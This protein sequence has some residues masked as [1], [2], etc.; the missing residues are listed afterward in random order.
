M[1]R[2]RPTFINIAVFVFLVAANYLLVTNP[3][4]LMTKLGVPKNSLPYIK[5]SLLVLPPLLYYFLIVYRSSVRPRT[6]LTVIATNFA[7]SKFLNL[8]GL[9][10]LLLFAALIEIVFFILLLLRIIRIVQK[11]LQ[12]RSSGKSRIDA[13]RETG[14]QILRDM[15]SN[16]I[17]RYI[18]IELSLFYYIYK[19]LRKE[20]PDSD[21]KLVNNIAG[22]SDLVLAISLLTIIEII[23]VHMLIY[24]YNTIAAWVVTVLSLYTL[25]WFWGDYSALRLEHS[26]VDNDKIHLKVGLRC[27]AVA[28]VEQIESY[29]LGE[30]VHEG[31]KSKSFLGASVSKKSNLLIKF[32]QPVKATIMFGIQRQFT[33]I[34][35]RIINVDDIKSALG[36]CLQTGNLVE[37]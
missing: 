19:N 21:G 37:A 31:L 35:L 6:V 18:F 23:P 3:F 12:L 28:P 17:Y 22:A 24:H 30:F 2:K 9:K 29:E 20:N 33:E 14:A 34:A 1:R 4:F 25:L 13:V 16:P 5:T 27:S 8:V 26:F 10:T 15:Q 11:Y 7:A 36:H 32:K